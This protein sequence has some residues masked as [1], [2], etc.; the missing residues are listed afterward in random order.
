MTEDHRHCWHHMDGDEIPGFSLYH[1]CRDDCADVTACAA[2]L[3][4][5]T[6]THGYMKGH[7]PADK[8]VGGFRVFLEGPRVHVRRPRAVE[9]T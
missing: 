1:C 4:M 2:P 9:G 5:E 7:R 3:V 8:V 6:K